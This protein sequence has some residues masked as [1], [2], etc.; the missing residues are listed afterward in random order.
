MKANEVRDEEGRRRFHGAFTGGFSAGYFNTVGSAEGWT[1]STFQSSREKRA[2]A[3][4]QKPED[5]MDEDD[6]LL[7]RHLTGT[8]DYTGGALK[9]RHP[10]SP[11]TG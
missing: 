1:P 2:D 9:R 3:K 4:V 6:G 11:S 8:Q 7:G 10:D 5:F